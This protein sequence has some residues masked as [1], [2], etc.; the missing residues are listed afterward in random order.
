[1]S[2]KR[3]FMLFLLILTA[4][5]PVTAVPQ[6]VLLPTITLTQ[7][8][9]ALQ[10]LLPIM[11]VGKGAENQLALSNDG[12]WLAVSTPLG[13]YLYETA[14]QREVWFHPFTSGDMYHVAFHVAFRPDGVQLALGS[15][16][17]ELLILDTLSGATVLTLKGQKF[18]LGNWSPDGKSILTSGECEEV[19]VWDAESGKV[20]HTIQPARCNGVTP[21]NIYAF[22][23]WDG[24]HIYTVYLDSLSIWDAATYQL[25]TN[26]QPD[27]DP[28]HAFVSL[29]VSSP[30]ENFLAVSNGLGIDILD[31]ETGK[32]LQTLTQNPLMG[33]PLGAV[34]WSRDGKRVLAAAGGATADTGNWFSIWDVK[35]GQVLSAQKM[36][37]ASEMAFMPDDE[38]LVGVSLDDSSDT[39]CAVN[40]TTRKTVFALTGFG[41]E[42]AVAWE[43]NDLL[44]YNG[45]T[46]TRWN[47]IVGRMI[48]Q[49]QPASAEPAWVTGSAQLKQKWLESN[50]AFK[51]S[52][53]VWSP[54]G[55]YWAAD[56]PYDELPPVIWD[57]QIGEASVKLPFDVGTLTPILMNMGWS[58][59]GKWLAGGGSLMN[60]TDD[61]AFIVLWDSQ[62]GKQSALLTA[63]MKTERIEALA[64]SHDQHWLA[65]GA[66]SGK[67]FLWDM[68][69]RH[70]AALLSGHAGSI[71]RLLWSANDM[72]L[73]STAQ[74]GTA[75][76]WKVP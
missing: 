35:T 41:S 23:S 67:I 44:T 39:I 36:S 48:E 6:P 55:R 71:L 64:W 68:Q 70:L 9:P 65:A 62:T 5:G 13:V 73:A 76:V 7:A 1:M 59:D 29:P 63:G 28:A 60:N 14:T 3:C 37:A 66:D 27:D 21:G 4:C 17:N 32:L 24:R 18:L 10:S 52:S 54:D 50:E 57:A 58:P 43:A 25:L 56:Q 42:Y 33:A 2:I 19:L 74:D 22:W 20:T 75:L 34:T 61:D 38:T 31:G 30:T 40:L 15:A 69:T 46:E 26:S 8:A 51:G 12:L 47:P 53:V 16:A 72:L 49:H 11:R 45:V